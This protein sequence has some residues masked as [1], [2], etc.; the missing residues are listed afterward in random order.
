MPAFD[1]PA[2]DNEFEVLAQRLG[3][4]DDNDQERSKIED[5]GEQEGIRKF[6]Y[7]GEVY[8]VARK[9]HLPGVATAVEFN[10]NWYAIRP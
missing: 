10:S 1:V 4:A 8:F 5:L 3:I 6:H 2:I 7:H 9:G